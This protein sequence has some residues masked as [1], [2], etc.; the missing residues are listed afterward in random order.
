MWNLRIRTKETIVNVSWIFNIFKPNYDKN[1]KV[2]D[3]N[4]IKSDW[5]KVGKDILWSMKQTK[6]Q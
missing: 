5:E 1:C 6:I 3:Y 2:I 4:M